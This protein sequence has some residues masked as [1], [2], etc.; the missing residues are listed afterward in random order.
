VFFCFVFI[1]QPQ[2][3]RAKPMQLPLKAA[4][5]Q[6]L[7]SEH[8]FGGQSLSLTALAEQLGDVVLKRL[9]SEAVTPFSI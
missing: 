7:P 9:A 4:C 5:V 3:F 2:H 1:V 6:S 8:L